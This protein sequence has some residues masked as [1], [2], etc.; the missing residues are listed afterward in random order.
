VH[1]VRRHLPGWR[2]EEPEGGFA[3]F[4]RSDEPGDDTALLEVA[5]AHGVSFDPAQI[6]RADESSSPLALRL[7]FSAATG[8]QLDEAAQRLGRAWDAY[9]RIRDGS[10]DQLSADAGHT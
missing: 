3:L 9:R 10:S 1:A 7:C 4:L 2:C 5:T 6:F 8:P